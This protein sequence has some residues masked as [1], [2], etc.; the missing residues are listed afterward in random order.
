MNIARVLRCMLR[1]NDV[2]S[3]NDLLRAGNSLNNHH[4]G[5]EKERI[6]Q[7]RVAEILKIGG[8]NTFRSDINIM[9]SSII[10]TISPV[11]SHHNNTTTSD[12]N[13]N[14]T[15]SL[16]RARLFSVVSAHDYTIQDNDT[17]ITPRLSMKHQGNL[18]GWGA[19]RAVLRDFGVRFRMRID[20]Y[21]IACF[22]LLVVSTVTSSK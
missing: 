10:P 14:N 8:F 3:G 17:A 2:G 16:N 9:D 20:L 21:C 5:E 19:A 15:S 11:Y 18:I 6:L 22:F 13:N 12:N 7:E 1:I 4:S